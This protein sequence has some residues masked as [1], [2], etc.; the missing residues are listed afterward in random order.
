MG[1]S[2]LPWAVALSTLL[3]AT[4][5]GPAQ[6]FPRPLRQAG[7]AITSG[8][9]LVAPDGE[10]SSTGNAGLYGSSTAPAVNG[11]VVAMAATPSGR[12]Y[13]LVSSAGE[14]FAYG[15]ARYFGCLPKRAQSS[16]LAAA[17]AATPDG[18]GYWVATSRGE[19]FSFGD[20]GNFGD[21]GRSDD[22]A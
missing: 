15:D 2:R 13:W 3:A 20:A 10:L 22:A 4:S 9:W 18:G 8:Y 5:G 7:P 16:Q 11:D 6:A 21:A 1:L 14:V 17:L 12:G 19:V